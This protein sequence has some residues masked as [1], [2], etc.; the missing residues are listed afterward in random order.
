METLLAAFLA[1]SA[2]VP[3]PGPGIRLAAG[4][5]RFAGYA[6]VWRREGGGLPRGLSTNRPLDAA[7]ALPAAP[8][9]AISASRDFDTPVGRGAPLKTTLRLFAVCPHGPEGGSPCPGLFYQ[10]QLELSGA[11]EG[12]C[13]ASLNGADALPFPVLQ[14][15][16][17]EKAD[18]KAWLG[19]TLHRTAL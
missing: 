10:V 18:P 4:E 9:Q 13:S 11:A 6:S 2:P 8:G 17:R 5:A 15:A 3:K 19:V 7:L 14:C 1:A 16:G 12:F